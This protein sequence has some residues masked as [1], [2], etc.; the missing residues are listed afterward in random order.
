MDQEIPR[1][2]TNQVNTAIVTDVD[3]QGKAPEQFAL[4]LNL[5]LHFNASG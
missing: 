4:D 3:F 2:P 1:V 5:D